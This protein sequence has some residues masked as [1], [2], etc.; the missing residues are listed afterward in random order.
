[1]GLLFVGVV[2]PCITSFS[3]GIPSY[4]GALEISG[5]KEVE[6]ESAP[7]TSKLISA[8]RGHRADA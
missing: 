8:G 1:M 6:G 2:S 7:S 5:Y 3:L 4:L